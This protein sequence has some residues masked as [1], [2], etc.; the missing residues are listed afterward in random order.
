MEN[1]DMLINWLLVLIPVGVLAR[2]IY[3]LCY[4]PVDEEQSALYKRRIR[5][6]F[7]FL[8]VAETAAG[9]LKVIESYLL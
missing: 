2:V 9:L 1:I 4:I 7:L 5:N 8:V 6:C 3:C